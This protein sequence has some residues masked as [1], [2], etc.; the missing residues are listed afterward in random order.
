MSAEQWLK[1][2]RQGG[3]SVSGFWEPLVLA[4]LNMPA[5]GASALLLATVI[6][7]GFLAGAGDA[8][9]MLPRST[10]HDLLVAPAA[11]AL[12]ARG[13]RLLAGQKA[14]RLLDDG[15]GR[16]AAVV[17]EREDLFEADVFV[18]AVPSWDVA[19]LAAGRRALLPLSEAA[20]RLG[21]SSIITVHLWFDR[22]WM[23]YRMAGL[24]G[25]AMHW[26]FSGPEGGSDGG[27]QRVTMVL[28]SA[29]GFMAEANAV[30]VE[31]C[32]AECERYFPESRGAR[33]G[34]SLVLKAR[35]S[36]IRGAPGQ[37][38]LR[39]TC[40]S[41]YRNARIAGDWTAT[42]LPATIEGAIASGARAAGE[43]LDRGWT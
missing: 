23:K 18:L 21:W 35:R 8:S 38:R 28:S 22:P 19:P 1:R 30:L 13:G 33:L 17:T 5:A 36:T 9:P 20:G 39:D 43:L 26:V 34:S 11:A 7:K 42:G 37:H 4:T 27:S 3:R 32:V 10:L 6:E 24:L 15:A 29:D 16:L 25:G 31:R 14:V 2:C 40:K 41:P 12:Q